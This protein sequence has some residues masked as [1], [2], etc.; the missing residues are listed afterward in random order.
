MTHAIGDIV[1]M[2]REGFKPRKFRVTGVESRLGRTTTMLAPA[3]ESITWE[4]D[5]HE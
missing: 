2:E 5:G 1:T 4:R 3:D